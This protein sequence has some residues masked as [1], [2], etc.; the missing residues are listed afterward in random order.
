MPVLTV[1]AGPNGAGK[2]TFA[3]TTRLETIDPD[4]IAAGYG[5]GFTPT[6]NLRASR[7]ALNIMREAAGG[8]TWP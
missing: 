2:S 8:F 1:I 5:E 6:A 3:Q 4:R 7:E